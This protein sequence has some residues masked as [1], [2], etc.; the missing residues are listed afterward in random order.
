MIL[1][2]LLVVTEE[3]HLASPVSWQVLVWILL[4][5]AINSMAAQISSLKTPNQIYQQVFIA[6][7]PVI[8]IMN[9]VQ[10]FLRLLFLILYLKFPLREACQLIV[11]KKSNPTTEDHFVHLRNKFY[12]DEGVESFTFARL[13]FF[14]IGTLPAVVKLCSFTGVPW[15]LA[16]G[17]MFPSSYIFMEVVTFVARP[18]ERNPQ[19]DSILLARLNHLPVMRPQ[20]TGYGEQLA[21]KL[22]LINKLQQQLEKARHYNH[23]M[24]NWINPTQEDPSAFSVLS[25]AIYTHSRLIIWAILGICTLVCEVESHEA[26]CRFCN[27][28]GIA[29]IIPMDIY[30]VIY[31]L[32]CLL[33]RFYGKTQS[34][35][36]KRFARWI[37]ISG[38]VS[39]EY[40]PYSSFVK[41]K[42]SEA[43][44]SI[45]IS[46]IYLLFTYVL[47]DK[48]LIP[49]CRRWPC[50][51][52]TLQ[53]P[54]LDSGFRRVTLD[55]RPATDH[56]MSILTGLGQS[57]DVGQRGSPE[58]PWVERRLPEEGDIGLMPTN[59]PELLLGN[60]QN[61]M[62]AQDDSVQQG[63]ITEPVRR[64]E[65]D[66]VDI[67][68]FYAVCLFL[69]SWVVCILWY[70]Y[71]YESSGTVNPG[72]TSV[73]G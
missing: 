41:I 66:V 17:L 19:E 38:L 16:L 3:S 69:V 20:D 37:C 64:S 11:I 44:G 14:V 8:C 46:M 55:H 49:L 18:G 27:E 45:V 63:N 54:P 4:T 6:S 61:T 28:M 10:S 59:D 22:E 71:V 50:I 65:N 30:I 35:F 53:T 51:T 60:R 7:S 56:E 47:Y 5:L 67:Y 24:W 12:K 72:W 73:F 68:T 52:K 39:Y 70:A 58:N 13:I 21:T 9:A 25:I 43:L 34:S 33:F 23:R 40:W 15:T 26:L 62:T 36:A 48:M 31:P 1:T 32:R 2:I 29:L 42:K 57:F